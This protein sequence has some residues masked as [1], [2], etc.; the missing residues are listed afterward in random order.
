M[1]EKEP[2]ALNSLKVVSK[3][4][5]VLTKR[6]LVVASMGGSNGLVPTTFH[7]GVGLKL[8]PTKLKDSWLFFFAF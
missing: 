8:P 4:Y 6:C 7:V 5:V 2:P 3:I 1:E